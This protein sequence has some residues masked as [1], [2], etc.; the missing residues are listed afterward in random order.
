MIWTMI[1]KAG[2]I[3]VLQT[4]NIGLHHEVVNEMKKLTPQELE[5]ATEA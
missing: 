4:L 3:I 2:V 5:E 1:K